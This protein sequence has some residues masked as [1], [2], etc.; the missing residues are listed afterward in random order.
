[1]VRIDG[2]A[3][4]Q[5]A[6][7]YASAWAR[8]TGERLVVST[9]Q[10][11][12]E[13][14]TVRVLRFDGQQGRH[15]LNALV[16]NLFAQAQQRCFITVPYFIPPRWLRRAMT[17]AVR[18][19]VDVRLMTSGETDV[20]PALYAGRHTYT[21][22]LQGGVRLF[23]Y[24]GQV[25]HDKAI[26]VDGR[27]AVVGSHNFDL[28]SE[29]HNLEVSV[30]VAEEKLSAELEEEFYHNMARCKA[31]DPSQWQQRPHY[32]RALEWCAFQLACL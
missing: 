15:R 17:E 12:Q 18:R 23:E 8:A 14:R 11:G 19:G 6:Q 28:W 30:A 32:R 2:P 29:R 7:V 4:G 24:F 16:Q 31:I 20:T 21:E 26:V 13:D 22:L 3:T 5:I 1:M 27:L 9:A 25:L 10:R